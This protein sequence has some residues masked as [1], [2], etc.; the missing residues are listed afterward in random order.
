MVRG[1]EA[2]VVHTTCTAGCNDDSLC[3]GDH[4]LLGLH[5]HKYCSRALTVL[6]KDQ[7]DSCGKVDYGDLKVEDLITKSSHDLRA[8]I[9]L[10]GVHTLA[11]GSA[12]VSGYHSSVGSLIELDAQLV[13]PVDGV[14]SFVYQLIKQLGLCGKVSAAESV[15]VVNC[16]RVVGLIS[17]LDS[18]LCHNGVGV[19]YTKLGH[20]HNVRAGSLG[21][22]SCRRACSATSDDENVNIVGNVVKVYR[23]CRDAAVSL[24]HLCEL[25]GDLLTLI[26]TDLEQ[27]ELVCTVVGVIGGKQ[28]FL[29]LCGHSCGLVAGI[30]LTTSFDLLYQFFDI[31]RIHTIAPLFLYL[32]VVVKLFHLGN[33][34]LHKVLE[35]LLVSTV[36]DLNEAVCQVSRLRGEVLAVYTA[37]KQRDLRMR[38]T[39]GASRRA[40][41]AHNA[42]ERQLGALLEVTSLGGS[43][44]L[45]NVQLL[46]TAL[47]A[48]V[49]AD[50]GID[51]GIELHH[52]LLV[53]SDRL[54]IVDLLDK[55][56]ERQ[57]RNVHIVLDLSLA[58][59][60]DLELFLSL[61]T[62]DGSA[63]AA[64]AV[65]ASATA[66]QLISGIFHS[67]HDSQ[68]ARHFI[69]LAE[70]IYINQ[71]FHCFIPLI[72]VGK[73]VKLVASENGAVLADV[74]VSD[75]AAAAL[76]DTALHTHLHRGKDLRLIEAKLDESCK[77]KLY[78]DRRSANNSCGR[79]LEI[80][81]LDVVRNESDVT[82]PALLLTV[83]CEIDVDVLVG[84]PFV[85][86]LAVVD[87]IVLRARTVYDVYM[88]VILTLIAAV[89]YDRAERSKADTAGD[90]EQVAS[91]EIALDG[92]SVSVRSANADLLS[93][94]HLM[95]P[96]GQTTA[97]LYRKFHKLF[98]RRR[99]GYREHRLSDTRDREHCALSGNVYERLFAVKSN[100]AEGLNVRRVYSYIG[101]NTEFRDQ[102]FVYHS[103]TSP[104]LFITFTIFI[105]IG[106]FFRHLPQPTQ[107]YTPSLFIG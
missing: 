44:V 8:G 20:D 42:V 57:S 67:R 91:L 17:S 61:N 73:F 41:S 92:E 64:E 21:L 72:F 22:D 105:E 59:E 93:D 106:H 40:D 71:F 53:V 31:R 28:L 94:V 65:T 9:V 95:E 50:A 5:V 87:K 70:K 103:V 85:Y 43:D 10:R 89:V 60:A 66:N 52:D 97:L 11:R 78:H 2:L 55:R 104:K 101:D 76:T 88:S 81:L 1:R 33:G 47:G 7:L 26:C 39:C 30:I 15:D 83:D 13:E 37:S 38:D 29:L 100:D 36:L 51:L 6:V 48:G 45:H 56:E 86:D 80:K 63:G 4:K 90:K 68:I 102:S 49:A 96:F 98:V 3:L 82:V 35:Q 84:A 24:K 32:A 79:G 46:S 74:L 54:N 58:C 99:R 25:V 14:R 77:S 75:V 12:S 23:V 19:A 69:F 16:G 107:P 34:L 18:A 27:L 62:V